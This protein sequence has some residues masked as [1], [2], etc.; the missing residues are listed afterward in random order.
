LNKVL[1]SGC[2]AAGFVR[3]RASHITQISCP[4]EGPGLRPPLMPATSLRQRDPLSA[5][6]TVLVA[7]E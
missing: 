2:R 3:G 7:P 1:F 5:R 6:R 4:P